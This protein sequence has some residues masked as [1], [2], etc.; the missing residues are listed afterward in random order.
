[1]ANPALIKLSVVT[2]SAGGVSVV[3]WQ[4]FNHLNKEED[5]TEVYLTKQKR[6]RASSAE[7]WGKIKDFYST[8]GQSGLIPSIL[9]QNVQANDI[10]NWCDR[11]LNKPLKEQTTENLRLIETWCSKPRTLT[12]QIT[13]LNRVPLNVDTEINSNPDK[14]TWENYANS[15][16]TS[17]DKFKI[18][19]KNNNNWVDFTASEAT[20]DIMKEWCKD[21]GSKQYKHS[22][23]SLFETYHKWC[24]K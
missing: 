10:K 17:G 3:G 4:I 21:N 20:A 13:A 22:E 19:K 16:K 12:A 1:M 11:E 8:A 24:S 5:K 14:N 7:E 2:L 15:Y 6:E 9:P 18:Q 23:D